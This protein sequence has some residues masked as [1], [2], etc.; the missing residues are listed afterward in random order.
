[1]YKAIHANGTTFIGRIIDIS[2][3][4]T[5]LQHDMRFDGYTLQLILLFLVGIIMNEEASVIVGPHFRFVCH[6][7]KHVS[8]TLIRVYMYSQ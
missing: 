4:L 5:R 2:V 3:R 6:C 8:Y 7:L 1:M